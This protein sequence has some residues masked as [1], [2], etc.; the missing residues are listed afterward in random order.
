M[1][2]AALFDCCFAALARDVAVAPPLLVWVNV[3][4]LLL[5]ALASPLETVE[6]A[7]PVLEEVDVFP[8]VPAVLLVVLPDVSSP[9]DAMLPP[10]AVA[11]AP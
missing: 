6:F 8:A 5:V 2:Q 9:P 7:V 4:L 11:L 3:V 1:Q 10:L